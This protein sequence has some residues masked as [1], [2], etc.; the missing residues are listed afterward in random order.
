MMR[1][2]RQIYRETTLTGGMA[3]GDRRPDR[4]PGALHHFQRPRKPNLAL[5]TRIQCSCQNTL[6]VIGLMNARQFKIS[7]DRRLIQHDIGQFS[8]HPLPEQT[9]F[10]HRKSMASRQ[11]QNESIAIKGFHSK[12]N[13]IFPE[14]TSVYEQRLCLSPQAGATHLEM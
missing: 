10:L 6:D 5:L 8:L 11:R 3:R 1:A 2:A 13:S 4:A 9:I 12:L 7:R 14:L